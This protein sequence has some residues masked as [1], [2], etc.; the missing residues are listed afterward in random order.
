VLFDGGDGRCIVGEL[1]HDAASFG[2]HVLGSEPDEYLYVFLADVEFV[3]GAYN[4]KG[5][6][7]DGSS[8]LEP[9]VV[10]GEGVGDGLGPPA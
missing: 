8:E 5:E 9:S 7:G 1:D 2:D 6:G 3:L 4:F 10:S